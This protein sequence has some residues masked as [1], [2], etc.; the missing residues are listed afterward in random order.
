MEALAPAFIGI[1]LPYCFLKNWILEM[2]VAYAAITEVHFPDYPMR[3][4]KKPR[5]VKAVV[6]TREYL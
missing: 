2:R 1:N 3:K 6:L 5:Q 4:H